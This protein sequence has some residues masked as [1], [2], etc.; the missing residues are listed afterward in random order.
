M[1]ING[2]IS[3]IGHRAAKKNMKAEVEIDP[4][5]TEVVESVVLVTTWGEAILL[6][7]VKLKL[8]ILWLSGIKF[9]QIWF[10]PWLKRANMRTN[11]GNP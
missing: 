5:S 8:R 3:K 11:S 1:Q 2:A 4:G 7:V 9:F 10:V 6:Y